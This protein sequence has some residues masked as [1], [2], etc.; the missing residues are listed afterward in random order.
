MIY[1]RPPAPPPGSRR[2][3]TVRPSGLVWER[4]S[5]SLLGPSTT[6]ARGACI[7]SGSMARRPRRSRR[8]SS[9]G[10]AG[11]GGNGKGLVA[12]RQSFIEP[13]TL[14]STGRAQRRGDQDQP[15]STMTAHRPALGLR[16]LRER[17][18][19]G[20]EGRRHPDVGGLSTRL[21]RQQEIPGADAAARRA[22]QC[23]HRRRAVAL[24]CGSVCEL[25]L[26][27]D[28]AQLPRLERLRQ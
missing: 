8:E 14:V 22:A 15:L 4:D 21:R 26:R 19:Q 13:P 27:G 1:D 20:R 10:G 12:I 7:A 3:G 23:H 24:E 6:P 18:L 9:F 5:R 17:H 28:L 25:G 11:A 2:N 16:A